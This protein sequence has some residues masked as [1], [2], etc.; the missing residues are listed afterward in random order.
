MSNQVEDELEHYH[1]TPRRRIDLGNVVMIGNLRDRYAEGKLTTLADLIGSTRQFQATDPRDLI[2]ALLGIVK[3]T[4]AKRAEDAITIDYD[5]TTDEVF[6]RAARYLWKVERSHGK[7]LEGVESSPARENGE[8]LPSWLPDYSVRARSPLGL[9]SPVNFFSGYD[10]HSPSAPE[11]LFASHG[12]DKGLLDV[13]TVYIDDVADCG[14][15][16]RDWRTARGFCKS[17]EIITGM[18]KT[19][20]NGQHRLEA[21]WRTLICN[22]FP[23]GPIVPAPASFVK[24]FKDWLLCTHFASF[25]SANRE[26]MINGAKKDTDLL[27]RQAYAIDWLRDDEYDAIPNVWQFCVY[28]WS[29]KAKSLQPGATFHHAVRHFEDMKLFVTKNGYLGL[30]PAHLQSGDRL[31]C[32]NASPW[33]YTLR[34]I[35]EPEAVGPSRYTF[36]GLAYVHDLCGGR[37][38]EL[39]GDRS[40][41]AIQNDEDES[42]QIS[43]AM[44]KPDDED[45]G[46][47][48][49]LM[50]T[51]SIF[52]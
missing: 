24:S 39:K 48:W 4:E 36:L 9:W 19:Y 2:F 41:R 52:C 44:A 46:K 49:Y 1:T 50:W 21:F 26:N 23:R 30:G 34:D 10:P 28:P 25:N 35:T 14:E 45:A 31:H 18:E 3:L 29:K 12:F 7:L 27:Q 22:I 43:K 32:A 20:Y 6:T 51:A 38:Q 15:P 16:L 37:F 13:S 8:K 5:L 40:W 47:K 17:L 42:F 33:F 11:S